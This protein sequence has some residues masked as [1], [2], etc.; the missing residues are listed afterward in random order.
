V[1][2]RILPAIAAAL[3]SACAAVAAL[4]LLPFLAMLNGLGSGPVAPDIWN[5]FVVG[6]LL[7]GLALGLTSLIPSRRMRVLAIG[8]CIVLAALAMV[9]SAIAQTLPEM[10]SGDSLI[11]IILLSPVLFAVGVVYLAIVAG[12][13]IGLAVGAGLL[14]RALRELPQAA[15]AGAIAVTAVG[16]VL[17]TLGVRRDAV[18]PVADERPQLVTELCDQPPFV[19]AV[20]RAPGVHAVTSRTARPTLEIDLWVVGELPATPAP[21]QDRIAGAVWTARLHAAKTLPIDLTV[22]LPKPPRPPAGFL[23][24]RAQRVRASFASHIAARGDVFITSIADALAD[25]PGAVVSC[26]PETVQCV[27]DP[28]VVMDTGFAPELRELHVDW[29]TAPR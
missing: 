11:A 4:R 10:K 14:A 2:A 23:D 16:A 28:I 18:A 3:A 22:K 20:R 15:Q 1:V 5:G 7:L 29:L 17:L 19:E 13:S 6:A 24:E 26:S 9:S 21:W 12:V 8:A 27:W 25:L